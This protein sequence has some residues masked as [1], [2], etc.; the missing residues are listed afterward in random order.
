MRSYRIVVSDVERGLL[1]KIVMGAFFT[2]RRAFYIPSSQEDEYRRRAG[3]RRAWSPWSRRRIC[4]RQPPTRAVVCGRLRTKRANRKHARDRPSPSM[5]GQGRLYMRGLSWPPRASSRSS[6]VQATDASFAG[7]VRGRVRPSMRPRFPARLQ[8]SADR[9][10][11]AR[12]HVRSRARKRAREC[13]FPGCDPC[14]TSCW[15]MMEP[16]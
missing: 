16:T 5:A 9:L 11:R 8:A 15:L 3:T 2:L 6:N 7:P 4:P 12:S 1:A 10:G 13:G 14:E